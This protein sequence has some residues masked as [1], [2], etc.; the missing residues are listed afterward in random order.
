MYS[1][2]PTP[3][4]NSQHLKA[5]TMQNITTLTQANHPL[6][7]GCKGNERHH[8]TSNASRRTTLHRQITII[9]VHP[10]QRHHNNQ[11]NSKKSRARRP[12]RS[13]R[14]SISTRR[15]LP[16]LTNYHYASLA[17]SFRG[18][19]FVVPSHSATS[20]I[21]ATRA[22]NATTTDSVAQRISTLLSHSA[23]NVIV[24]DQS[25]EAIILSQRAICR[26]TIFSI[27]SVHVTLPTNNKSYIAIHHRIYHRTPYIIVLIRSRAQSLCLLRHRCHMNSSLFTCNLPTKLVSSKRSIRRTTL[28]RLTRRANIIPIKRSNIVFSR[29]KTFCSSRNV[30]SRLTGV[31]I[32]RL[33]H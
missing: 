25:H 27:R 20:A 10:K 22:T 2:Q 33:Q 15:P 14:Q 21:N 4:S 18:K 3:S 1:R 29:I 24:S 13:R 17:A 16:K 23:S 11:T 6:N 7:Q 30:D 32:V 26:K 19:P 9:P 8:H 5:N 28:H 31:V 12:C